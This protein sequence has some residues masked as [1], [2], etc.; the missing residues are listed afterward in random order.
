[1]E[2]LVVTTWK[3]ISF[4]FNGALEQGSEKLSCKIFGKEK[5]KGWKDW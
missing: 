1:M 3:R 4:F 2:Y 5:L